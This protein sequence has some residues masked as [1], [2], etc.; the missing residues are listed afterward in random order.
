VI[1]SKINLEG[2]GAYDTD[3]ALQGQSPY[4]VNV[5]LSHNW[6]QTGLNTTLVYNIIGDRVA[7]VGTDGYADIYE[8]HRNLLDFQLSKRVWERG[9][10]KLTWSDIFR[11]DFMY[12]QDNNADHKFNEDVD[13]IM[14]QLNNGSSITLGFSYRF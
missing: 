7:Q 9:E 11:P 4:I 12:Y 2:A 5:G 14:Q 10:I 8:R 13:N 3:R 1:R 6:V